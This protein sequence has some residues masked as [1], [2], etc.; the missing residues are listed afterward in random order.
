MHN[1]FNAEDAKNT[2]EDAKASKR[3]NRL[4]V[5]RVSFASSALK[6]FLSAGGRTK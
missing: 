4:S 2:A 1:V 6:R 5:L 3:G